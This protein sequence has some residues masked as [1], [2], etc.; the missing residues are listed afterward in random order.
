MPAP[1]HANVPYGP[2]ARNVFDLWLAESEKPT[3][4]VL[5]IH[6]GGFRQGDK[7]K[8]GRTSL[9]RHLGAGYSVAAVNY[10]LTNVAPAPAAYLDCARALQ[11]LRYNAKKWNLDKT[12]VASTG[13]SAG[14]GTSMWLA[15]HDDLADPGSSDPVARESTRLTCISVNNGQCS[16][17]P[18]FV[19]ELGFPRPNLERHKLFFPFYGIARDEVDTPKAYKLYEQAAAI[20]YLTP[21]DPPALLTYGYPD[22]DADPA[23][24]L[25]AV[26]H[27]PRFGIALKRGRGGTR[28]STQG[29]NGPIWTMEGRLSRRPLSNGRSP[30]ERPAYRLSP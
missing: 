30:C 6:G 21:D 17:D 8:L 10:R 1:T 25:G 4:L 12:R 2:H 16:Y 5:F 13:G 18:R 26:V 27:H 3:P 29:R 9:A 28:P 7:S 15:F 22:K 23:S 14:A 20:T 19:A 24:N 11:F